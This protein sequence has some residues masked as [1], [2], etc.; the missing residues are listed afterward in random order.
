MKKRIGAIGATLALVP[1]AWSA[2][3]GGG[4]PGP[5]LR[6]LGPTVEIGPGLVGDWGL[7]E[8]GRAA[9]DTAL[10]FLPPRIET[11]SRERR[12]R[13][14]R[15]SQDYD[16]FEPWAK[17]GFYVGGSFMFQEIGGDFDGDTV[18]FETDGDD[19][20]LVPE[21]D[22]GLGFGLVAGWR[23]QRV[24]FE[25]SYRA[26][27]HDTEFGSQ[28]LGHAVLHAFDLDVKPYFLTDEPVQP[29]LL[30]G[31]S[32][33]ILVLE[34]A[35]SENGGIT[36]DE[37]ATLTGMGFNLGGGFSVFATDRLAVHLTGGY[38]LAWFFDAEGEEIDNEI[39]G[40]GFFASAGITFTF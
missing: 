22:P 20:I 34:D 28:D 12:S 2:T 8:E 13:E 21:I 15:P 16:E 6:G 9:P 1:A 35:R 19:E 10:S 26:T 29:F 25:M 30:F 38:R 5:T 27:F 32:L 40:H 33:P 36:F 24:A 14:R 7:L 11:F 39:E 31:M 18:L 37:D 4:G 3:P 23:T 17:E